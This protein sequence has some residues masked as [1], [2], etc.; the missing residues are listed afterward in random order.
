MLTGP[1]LR[2]GPAAFL[3]LHCTIGRYTCG[4]HPL[5]GLTMRC[6]RAY[7]GLLAAALALTAVPALAQWKWKDSRGQV[8]ISDLP[9]PRE[10]PDKDVLQR[11]ADTAR[12][13]APMAGTPASAPA[14]A[15][16]PPSAER[17]RTDPEIEARRAKAEQ[18]QKAK[19]RAEEDKIAAQRAENCQRARQHITTLESGMRL[20]RVNEKGEREILDDKARAEEMARAR[21]IVQSECR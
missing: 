14:P 19:A 18:D 20:G 8:H 1:D 2:R 3:P 13:P 7:F 21:Q 12:K 4:W 11:P 5:G 6:K 10:I 16:S 9:P 17:P 15:A